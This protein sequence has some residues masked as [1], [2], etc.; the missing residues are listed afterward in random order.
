MGDNKTYIGRERMVFVEKIS[1]GHKIPLENMLKRFG[2]PL[3]FD[4]DYLRK[5]RF[6]VEMQ[7]HNKRLETSNIQGFSISHFEGKEKII[8]INTALH[9]NDWISDY[10]RVNIIKIYL[11][12]SL[13]NTTKGFDFD[14]SFKGY[15]F[16]CDYREDALVVPCFV[17]KII[18]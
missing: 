11:L 9:I 15:N 13:G 16:E 17:Y 7:V 6:V 2:L 3:F 1:Y 5:N 12:D 18:E 4:M 10:D 8:R 14:V